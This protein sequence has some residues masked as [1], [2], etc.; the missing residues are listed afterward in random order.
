MVKEEIAERIDGR[1]T[2]AI[3]FFFKKRGDNN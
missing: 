1:R 3:R 2:E